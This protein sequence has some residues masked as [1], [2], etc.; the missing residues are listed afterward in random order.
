MA[1]NPCDLKPGVVS[2]ILP[3]YNGEKYLSG[4]IDS[5]LAQT[6]EGWELLVTDDGS[7]DATAS[8]CDRYA[9]ADPRIKVFHQPNGG[10]NRARAK[11]IDNAC[12]EYLTF[13]DADDAFAPD[14]LEKMVSAFTPDVDIVCCGEASE[15]LSQ[16]DYISALWSYRIELGI[17]TKMFR[18]D[19]F[20]QMDYTLDPRIVMGEDLLL[21]SVY[22]LGVR[23]AVI[24]PGDLYLINHDNAGSVQRN[25]KR[26]WE[27]EKYYFGKVEDLFLSKCAGM[28]SCQ[29]IKQQVYQSRV[30]GMKLLLIAGNK[31]E[32]N[33]PEFK[34]IH[35]YFQGRMDVLKPSERLVLRLKV[36]WLYRLIIKAYRLFN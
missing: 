32:Y 3:A 1:K 4:A 7:T 14:A 15:I 9:A 26:S 24:V 8:I 27:Y 18:T 23:R 12:G 6:Y 17:C 25:F 10:V 5:V 13:L 2:V 31:P 36:P 30:N 34:M 29:R 21:N 11:G 16:E 20:R 19:L 33:D 22:S 35:D 28:E